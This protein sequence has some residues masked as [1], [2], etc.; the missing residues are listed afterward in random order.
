MQ[1]FYDEPQ[2]VKELWNPAHGTL[3]RPRT[4]SRAKD[5]RMRKVSLEDLGANEDVLIPQPN[6]DIL[7]CSR[8]ISP[9]RNTVADYC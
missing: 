2:S 5:K 1:Y 3:I 6:R 8:N 7:R 4:F 9:S